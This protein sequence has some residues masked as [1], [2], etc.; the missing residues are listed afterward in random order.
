MGRI[1]LIPFA[2]IVAMLLV[3]TS[4]RAQ[5]PTGTIAGLVRDAS[6]AVVAGADI[7]ITSQQTGIERR[8]VSAEDGRYAAALLGHCLKT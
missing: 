7:T 3:P 1:A 8:L 2:T 5:A 4:A 6:G